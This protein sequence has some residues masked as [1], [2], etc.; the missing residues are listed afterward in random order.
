MARRKTVKDQ[1]LLVIDVQQGLF[2][3]KTPVFNEKQLLA[4]I[5]TLVQR[6]HAKETPVIFVQ[7]SSKDWLAEGSDNWQLHPIL[8]PHLAD[9]FVRKRSAS[10]FEGTGL[11]SL[12]KERKI[13]ALWVVGLATHQCVRASCLDARRLGYKVILV[14]DGHSSFSK[15]AA[16]LIERWNKA[17]S[18]ETVELRKTGDIWFE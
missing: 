1:A 4:N 10:A 13:E 6:A 11:I 17:L 3:R 14:S 8:R 12:L 7:H 15:D 18:V 16:G 9:L 2:R 5:S